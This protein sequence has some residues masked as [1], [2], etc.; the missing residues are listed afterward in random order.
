MSAGVASLTIGL[1]SFTFCLKYFEILKE[2]AVSFSKADS[3][4]A[5]WSYSQSEYPQRYGIYRV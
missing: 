2:K 4:V 3:F 1:F 5:G